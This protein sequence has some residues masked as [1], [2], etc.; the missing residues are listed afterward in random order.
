MQSD[1]CITQNKKIVQIVTMSDLL[2][3]QNMPQFNLYTRWMSLGA[4]GTPD[5]LIKEGLKRP[6]QIMIS[7]EKSPVK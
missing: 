3:A 7:F 5:K 6:N 1:Q 4:D 2:K